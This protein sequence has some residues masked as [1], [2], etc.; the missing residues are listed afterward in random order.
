MSSAWA[1]I[2]DGKIPF[3]LCAQHHF[4]SDRGLLKVYEGRGLQHLGGS[5][6]RARTLTEEFD[7]RR[8][9]LGSEAGGFVTLQALAA[10]Q[11]EVELMGEVGK[12]VNVVRSHSC[13][14][15]NT[16]LT[17]SRMLLC[18]PCLGDLEERLTGLSLLES[19]EVGQH[20]ALGLGHLHACGIL[21]R[22]LSPK[23][24]LRG[25]DGF[26]KL[27]DFSCACRLSDE[28]EW[29]GGGKAPPE[30]CRPQEISP[31]ADVWL[32]GRLLAHIALHADDCVS[33]VPCVSPGV[34]MDLFSARLWVLLHWFLAVV[35][36]HRPAAG[37]AAALLGTVE[38][39]EAREVL[40]EMPAAVHS[41]ITCSVTAAARSVA[42]DGVG[43]RDPVLD[44]LSVADL[45]ELR[46]LADIE[47]LCDNC[48][49]GHRSVVKPA[50]LNAVGETSTESGSNY[51]SATGSDHSS[52]G[53]TPIDTF[54][55]GWEGNPFASDSPF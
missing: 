27:G 44:R 53:E 9:Q 29:R 38:F 39:L 6:T 30:A 15:E 17:H 2:T 18:D 5:A 34:L 52:D 21:C 55:I 51:I 10:V 7:L 48:G 4:P 40:A 50:S 11:L 46:E 47:R 22:A 13:I 3:Q 49:F 35:P 24:V 54:D 26:W 20:C 12:H 28:S 32:L 8:L 33:D 36:E 37:E 31:A 45:A 16:G 41:R 42:A 19:L 23:G 25:L 1:W 43:S 14:I